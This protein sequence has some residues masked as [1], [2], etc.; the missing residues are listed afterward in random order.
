MWRSLYSCPDVVFVRK[1]FDALG[2][3]DEEGR[4]Q[5]RESRIG[6]RD[7]NIPAVLITAGD[8]PTQDSTR[9]EC[10]NVIERPDGVA[11]SADSECHFGGT[12]NSS[13]GMCSGVSKECFP[14]SE[15][16]ARMT[17]MVSVRAGVQARYLTFSDFSNSS[18]EYE[19]RVSEVP[20]QIL[21]NVA[22]HRESGW[23]CRH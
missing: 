16:D 3:I 21:Q 20:F 2:R 14:Q 22:H 6:W 15:S 9:N 5:D 10:G 23:C 18:E 19:R 7:P 4:S 11:A 8:G 13:R 1:P 17:W 12:M